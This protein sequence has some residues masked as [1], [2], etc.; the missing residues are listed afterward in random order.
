[1]KWNKRF[2]G[3]PEFIYKDQMWIH[4]YFIIWKNVIEPFQRGFPRD[5]EEK[6][7]EKRKAREYMRE[8]KQSLI[9]TQRDG[10]E[11]TRWR[12]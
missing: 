3:K 10:L 4:L 9:Y 1:M 11:K 6:E 12:W 2:E 5:L 7:V 8:K